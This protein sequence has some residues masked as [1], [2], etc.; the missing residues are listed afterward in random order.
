MATGGAPARQNI[1]RFG[2]FELDLD[3][4][5]LSRR[6]IRLKLQNQPCQVLTLLIQR[7]PEIVARDEIRER[8]WGNDV[9][10]DTERSINFC[11]RQIRGAL[12]DNAVSPRFIETLPRE[13]YR[14]IAALEGVV[15]Q[16]R[17][18][19]SSVAPATEE[20]TDVAARTKRHRWAMVLIA[21]A[22]F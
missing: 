8:V 17:P 4:Q 12:L 19:H 13:G 7:A 18:D 3:R 15:Q 9:Y 1:L 20:I 16:E 5:T 6:G 2:E 22:H 11:I 14:F 21:L 10:I